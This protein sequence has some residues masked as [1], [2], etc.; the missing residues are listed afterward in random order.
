MTEPFSN[1]LRI[2]QTS[3]VLGFYWVITWLVGF[4][5]PYMVDEMAADLGVNVA[6]IWFGI[7]VLS[8]IWAFFFVPELAG[9]SRAEV[10]YVKFGCSKYQVLT[11]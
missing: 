7:G 8:I 10:C 2:T 6:Y 1:R 11:L 9:L 4:V 5:T 3:L